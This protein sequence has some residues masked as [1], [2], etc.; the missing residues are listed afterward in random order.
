MK[1]TLIGVLLCTALLVGCSSEIVDQPVIASET[2]LTSECEEKL[3]DLYIPNHVEK[4]LLEPVQGIYT[5]AYVESNSA[6]DNDIK[7]FEELVGSKQAFRVMQYQG[8]GDVTSRQMLECLANKQTPY[9]KIMMNQDYDTTPIYHLVSDVKTKYKEP[10][11]IELYPVNRE[12]GD[13]EAYKAYYKTSYEL[14]KKH[15]DNAV[16]VWSVDI[17]DVSSYVNYYPG[18]NMVDWVG[19]NAYLPQYESGTEYTANYK[20]G[21]DLWY[22][23]FQSEKPLILSGVAISHYS[24]VDHTYQIAEAVN[25][26][27]YFY[28]TVPKSYPRIKG[29]LY[30][31]VDMAEVS[32]EG[33]E[34]YTLSSQ[35]ELV[36]TYHNL[37]E[38][39][40]F[41]GEIEEF[42]GATLTVPMKY[43]VPVLVV[44]G[45][46][47]VAKDYAHVLFNT[48]DIRKIQYIDYV[49][50][51]RY[52]QV[53][54]LVEAYNTKH[55]SPVH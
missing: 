51:N 11:F 34:D 53:Q 5:G 50:E 47:Y 14:I 35:K 24:R 37:M 42:S 49:D 13:P 39:G 16:V 26:L 44:D 10:V 4:G 31:D 19:L 28:D 22:K 2:I 18:N 25:L 9:I 23:T 30:I 8:S 17:E 43:T 36:S 52:Y 27:N 15:L 45:E 46:Y 21:L 12:T 33:K 7:K 54:S 32:S 40:N 1:K 48:L 55:L 3:V 6:L 41:L 38:K 20:E 29:I